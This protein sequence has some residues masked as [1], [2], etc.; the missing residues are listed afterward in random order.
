MTTLQANL[1]VPTNFDKLNLDQIDLKILECLVDGAP[2]TSNNEYELKS[3]SLEVEWAVSPT[4]N[5]VVGMRNLLLKNQTFK[6]E[7]T[8]K[9]Q[10]ADHK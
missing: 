5:T 3:D 6:S 7:R 2:T 10:H 1:Y 4:L 9:K 8:V